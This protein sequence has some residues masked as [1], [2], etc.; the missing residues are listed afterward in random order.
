MHSN[1]YILWPYDLHYSFPRTF[2][3][4]EKGKTCVGLSRSIMPNIWRGT[5]KYLHN[6]SNYIT[7]YT[8]LVTPKYLNF[9]H[10]WKKKKTIGKHPA[11][12][13]RE[14]KLTK[15]SNIRFVGDRKPMG[16]RKGLITVIHLYL[17][18]F[19]VSIW[20]GRIFRSYIASRLMAES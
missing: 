20:C 10:Y 19:A 14:G 17:W 11:L 1:K 13:S 3:N 12:D 6:P 7:Y 4:F 5:P 8:A 18:P 15:R 2:V 9:L 16:K